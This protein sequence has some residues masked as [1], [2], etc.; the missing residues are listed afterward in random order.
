MS[1]SGWAI[2]TQ[3]MPNDVAFVWGMRILC[4]I[5]FVWALRATLKD[6]PA[7]RLKERL[8]AVPPIT[9][10]TCPT[11][12]VMLLPSEPAWECPQC[13]MKRQALPA[14]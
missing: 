9:D 12:H 5:A 14:V 7:V 4:P 11:C 1:L 10:S 3:E 8:Q 6:E 13:G 2:S